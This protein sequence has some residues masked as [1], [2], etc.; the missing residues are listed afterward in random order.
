MK[1][2][3]KVEVWNYKRSWQLTEQDRQLKDMAVLGRM[4]QKATD[5]G[6]ETELDEAGLDKTGV[7]QTEDNRIAEVKKEGRINGTLAT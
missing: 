6:H 2:D 5:A 7:Q 3:R 1:Q 4:A